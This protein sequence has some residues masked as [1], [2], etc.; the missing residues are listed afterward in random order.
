MNTTENRSNDQ[1]DRSSQEQRWDESQ[2]SSM[3]N[4]SNEESIKNP[5]YSS[6]AEDS[7]RAAGDSRY[8]NAL[9]DADKNRDIYENKG[10]TA[11]DFEKRSVEQIRMANEPTIEN[12]ANGTWNNSENTDQNRFNT[13]QSRNS[14]FENST[15]NEFPNYANSKTQKEPNSFDTEDSVTYRNQND[16][17]TEA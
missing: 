12:E 3:L 7:F 13:E 14:E 15:A 6:R 4:D 10:R 17:E 2:N 9:K 5:T 1:Q 16:T 8:D 11:E